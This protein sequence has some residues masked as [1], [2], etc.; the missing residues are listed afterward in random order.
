MGIFFR[1]T[2]DVFFFI[3]FILHDYISCVCIGDYSNSKGNVSILVC[4]KEKIIHSARKKK[5]EN[6]M[7]KWCALFS[8]AL[9]VC[10]IFMGYN[11]FGFMFSDF[12]QFVFCVC[13]CVKFLVNFHSSHITNKRITSALKRFIFKSLKCVDR[14]PISCFYFFK[15]HLQLSSRF[16]LAL[17]FTRRVFFLLNFIIKTCV[18]VVFKRCFLL[19][20]GFIVSWYTI[21]IHFRIF[22]HVLFSTVVAFVFLSI[23]TC[24]LSFSR[25]CWC[26]CASQPIH[27]QCHS[28]DNKHFSFICDQKKK[29]FITVTYNMHADR[30]LPRKCWKYK[31]NFV[32]V[33]IHKFKWEIDQVN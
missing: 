19:F 7:C 32:D 23:C 10:A 18:F 4:K 28:A 9:N 5:H 15:Q 3:E 21:F 29:I 22:V 11:S 14:H 17:S 16:S 12:V 27:F 2:N 13:V 8:V 25:K 20:F 24:A 31:I 30:K 1:R 6:H 26:F 33:N